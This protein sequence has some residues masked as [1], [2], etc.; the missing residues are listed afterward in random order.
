MLFKRLTKI[1]GVS[2]FGSFSLL[3]NMYT[4]CENDPNLKSSTEFF[5]QHLTKKL[6]QNNGDIVNIVVKNTLNFPYFTKAMILLGF[7][8]DYKP[9]FDNTSCGASNL[10]VKI[11]LHDLYKTKNIKT[12]E[13]LSRYELIRIIDN[14]TSEGFFTVELYN[15]HMRDQLIIGHILVVHKI[16]GN[17][18]K[19]YQGFV[20]HY[21]LSDYLQNHSKDYTKSEIMAFFVDMYL[22]KDEH[23]SDEK[24]KEIFQSRFNVN[25]DHVG[26]RNKNQPYIMKFSFTEIS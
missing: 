12:I 24:I 25:S 11:M 16:N 3:N 14:Y 2:I 1:Y 17:K 26:K 4:H 8:P 13:S 23:I 5:N 19:I 18:Y 15:K 20:K 6:E 7:F 9:L 10:F 21:S 22:L